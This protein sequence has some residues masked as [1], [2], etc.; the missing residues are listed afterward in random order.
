[1]VVLKKKDHPPTVNEFNR[2]LSQFS[3]DD[4]IGHIFT[5]DSKFHE[6]NEKT[7]LFNELYPPIKK[8]TNQKKL[9]HMKDLRSNYSV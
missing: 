7:L 4:K 9:I 3:H 2:I 5:V 1:M 8:K 6:M